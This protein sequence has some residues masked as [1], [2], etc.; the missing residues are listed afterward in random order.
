MTLLHIIGGIALTVAAI[1]AASL[2]PEE[3]HLH[4]MN[5]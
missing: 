3:L 4:V 5:R 1:L 2:T